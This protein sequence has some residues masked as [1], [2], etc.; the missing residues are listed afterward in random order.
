[1][2]MTRSG[3]SGGARHHLPVVVLHDFLKNNKLANAKTPNKLA[4]AKTHDTPLDLSIKI[5][6]SEPVSQTG[7]TSVSVPMDV[8][9]PETEDS[10]ETSVPSIKIERTEPV[11]Q[12]GETS[13]P[14]PMD[15]P[16]PETEDSEETS[17]GETEGSSMPV[18]NP[19][20]NLETEETQEVSTSNS[21]TQKPK[22]VLSNQPIGSII[23]PPSGT[24]THPIIIRPL[25]NS[26]GFH[27]IKTIPPHL[28]ERRI[29]IT[30][31][32]QRPLHP[33]L[34][35]PP[36]PPP[37]PP[38]QFLLNYPPAL[39]SP[40]PPA[41]PP[42]PALPP[43]SSNTPLATPPPPPH[44]QY[45]A[46]P[47]DKITS[48]VDALPPPPVLATP[49]VHPTPTIIP[50]PPPQ[51]PLQKTTLDRII[52]MLKKRVDS[53]STQEKGSTSSTIESE[54]TSDVTMSDQP[55]CADQIIAQTTSDTDQPSC[56][57]QII[58]QTT[59][60]SVSGIPNSSTIAESN[61]VVQR[62]SDT[63]SDI[64]PKK[65]K[66][67]KTKQKKSSKKKGKSSRISSEKTRSG[68][69]K[70]DL[71]EQTVPPLK[72]VLPLK[73]RKISDDLQKQTVLPLK[74][75]KM[76]E[77]NSET[78]EISD[79][80]SD[81]AY[82]PLSR[83]KFRENNKNTEASTINEEHIFKLRQSEDDNMNF[84]T[85]VGITKKDEHVINGKIYDAY[86]INNN[87]YRLKKGFVYPSIPVW[88]MLVNIPLSDTTVMIAYQK[89]IGRL[90][91]KIVKV[92][93]KDFPKRSENHFMDEG[94]SLN[95]GQ[96]VE[97]S[98][99]LI[100]TKSILEKIGKPLLQSIIDASSTSKPPPIY[101]KELGGGVIVKMTKEKHNY[102]VELRRQIP[103]PGR[104]KLL[105][106]TEGYH[107]SI[108]EW[109][110]L[111]KIYP[112]C[113]HIIMKTVQ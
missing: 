69:K 102:P 94:I 43:T 62:A 19:N 29:L 10:E 1:M 61:I 53:T 106:T 45:N 96:F 51:P 27:I 37:Q 98:K 32:L 34:S 80:D 99:A 74:K 65:Q 26:Q 83:K 56:A 101:H 92:H 48:M 41:T 47:L 112:H 9:I 76:S 30:H 11:S 58:A 8:P 105:N 28:P 91:T 82:E 2:M 66:N 87:I 25:L 42:I 107:F 21:S 97:L 60:D 63:M 111:I 57:D 4:R 20:P 85:L 13:V 103:F 44:S 46:S 24:D 40:S 49:A 50:P 79:S 95:W 75:R 12:T 35:V 89:I 52:T 16:M 78:T 93:L 55:S 108:A 14:V 84:K 110:K 6:R 77:S 109:G 39:P 15:V 104:N 81:E 90:K 113:F 31:R 70:P 86:A 68:S 22:E 17:V 100:E 67:S 71:Q 59:S 3:K 7:E 64:S 72:I 88:D 5:E 38:S 18:P 23:I 54:I 36:S 33:T 73:K